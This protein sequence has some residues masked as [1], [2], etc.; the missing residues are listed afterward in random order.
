MQTLGAQR[1]VLLTHSPTLH[2]KQAAGLDQTL[3][4][5]SGALAELAGV[6]ERG[7]ARRDRAGIEAAIARITRPR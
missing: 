6:L 1:R 7:K 4:K 3:A 5:A 2:A